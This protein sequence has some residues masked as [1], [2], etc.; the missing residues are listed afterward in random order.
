VRGRATGALAVAVAAAALLRAGEARAQPYDPAF[1]WRT[2]ETPHFRLHFHQGEEALAQDVA[3]ES[4]RAHALL[5]P[6]LGFEPRQRTEVVLSDDVDDANGSATPLPY[7]TIRLY[8]VPPSSGSVLQDY[9]DWVRQLVQHEYTHILHL[10]HVGGV[11]GAFNRIFGKLWIP[12][13][14]V[15]PFFIEGLAVVNESEGDPASGRNASALFDMYARTLA[16]DGP[17]PRLDEASNPYLEWPVGNVPYLLGGR[18]MGYL[19]ARYGAPAVAGWI[20]DQGR[21]VWP[22]AP[23]WAGERWFGGK[24]F[25]EL[26]AEY[27]A[28]E[29]AYAEGRRARVRERPVTRPTPLT[30]RGGVV[31]NP[32]FSPDG[33]F[34]LYYG[35]SLDDAPGIFRVAPDGRDL[36]RVTVVDANGTLALRSPREAL[37]AIGE[38]WRE[39]RTYDDLWLVDVE[40]GRR[41]RVTRGERATDPDVSADGRTAVYVRRT[42][43]GGMALV[44]RDLAS[45]S[46]AVLFARDGAQVF[47]PRISRDGAVAFELHEGGRRDVAVW[48]DGRVERVTDDDALDT[49][50]AWTPDGRFL[51]FASD[52]GGIYDVYAWEPATGRL[53]QVT[54]VETGALQPEVS[55]DG[56]T[57]AFVSYGRAGYDLATIPLDET[58]WLDALP[59]PPPVPAPARA[60]GPDAPLP[61]RPY[62]PWPTLRPTLWL[63]VV[64]ADGAGTTWGAFTGGAD[65]L[66]RHVWT[67][68]AW[69]SAGGQEPGYS[70]AYQGGWSWPRLDLSSSVALLESPGP[71][72]RL[73]RVW[74]Y[75]D[76]GLTF[77][78]TR[79]ARA[80]AVRVGWSGTRY[81]SVEPAAPGPPV[82]APIRFEDGFL[83]DL[84]LG[85]AY[86]DARRFVHSI[87]P[88]E[89]RV[90]TLR[91]RLA[92]PEIGSDFRL[93]RARGDVA[94]YVRIPATRHAV[95][96]LRLA[97][98]VAEGTIGG[99]A[100]FELGG[101]GTASLASLVPG[102]FPASS[103]QLR[104]Y[105]PG[106]LAGTG[107]VLANAEVR[108]PLVAPGR[109]RSTW[110]IFL[111]RVHAAVFLDVGDAFDR[112]G[113][114]PFAGH[115]L[116][117]EQL[118]FGAGAELRTE[119]VLG[120]Y[121]RTDLRIGIA[122]GL[123][124]L[125]GDG[126]EADRAAGI[127][128]GTQVYVTV[129]PSF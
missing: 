49:A 30:R 74:T 33:R 87:S 97:G 93:A 68:Q 115:P 11:P 37:V 1:R 8:A 69:W 2:I 127:D 83:S 24:A 36:G 123:G 19:Q 79:L 16:L 89:G 85:A 6:R 5:A 63:P 107:F 106:A 55:P 62:S 25:P 39:Y 102:A 58:T 70:V 32:R 28:A 21:Y 113:E 75:G 101:A 10:D 91:L 124:A 23:S 45:G 82:P 56:R 78:W 12:N 88:E 121:L 86:S 9:R 92:G 59:A 15:P 53:R 40:S 100:P 31:E 105:P 95:L 7:D 111:S 18:F 64:A 129:G 48:R 43:G 57:L 72:D 71:P 103:D 112:P 13:G 84:S 117:A 94:Q 17:F 90:A 125:L 98:G 61:S 96:A 118:R 47:L 99:N 35:R 52:R 65:V 41:R 80:L 22:Y 109:G 67:L 46:T 42:G 51:L 76:A 44:R 120:Y 54:N 26:W 128:A 110:P 126:R 122:T 81:D 114:L 116:E 119:I 14:L 38:V 50:P 4:E 29:R 104:G 3:R 60:E 108:F 77:T 20:G 66:L 27:A 73:Q 34:L